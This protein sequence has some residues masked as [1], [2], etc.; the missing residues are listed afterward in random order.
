MLFRSIVEFNTP[1]AGLPKLSRDF[2]E[3][4]DLTQRAM[5]DKMLVEMGFEPDED[6]VI[7]TYGEGW[8]RKPTQPLPAQG[9]MPGDPANTTGNE[10]DDAAQDDDLAQFAEG[11]P[12][13]GATA[14]R[15][16]NAARQ[17][18]IVDASEQLAGQ[19]KSL[20]SKPVEDLMSM[21][22]ETGDLVQFRERMTQL[23]DAAPADAAVE[24]IARATFAGH[25]MGRGLAPAPVRRSI[26]DKLLALVRRRKGG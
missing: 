6:Y 12:L 22:D 9:G 26:K 4:E 18:A 1:G 17:Q 15:A 13:Q 14:Q 24:T 8:H 16:F 23:V 5:R 7:D 21:L 2:A 3:P 25:V 11:R 20:M 10:A 19:W